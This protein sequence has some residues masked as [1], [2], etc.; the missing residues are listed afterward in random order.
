MFIVFRDIMVALLGGSCSDPR[1]SSQPKKYFEVRI[2]RWSAVGFYYI[3]RTISRPGMVLFY[4][5][6]YTH[7]LKFSQLLSREVW[8][9]S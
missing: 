6:E 1:V 4:R 3:L 5:V 9:S 7:F 8:E 2:Y